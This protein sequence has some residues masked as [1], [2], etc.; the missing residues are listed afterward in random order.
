MNDNRN[1]KE[2]T[3]DQPSLAQRYNESRAKALS[4]NN[5][6]ANIDKKPNNKDDYNRNN[7]IRFSDNSNPNR[8]P[9]SNHPVSPFDGANNQAQFGNNNANQSYSGYSRRNYSGQMNSRTGDN[10]YRGYG[11]TNNIS[12]SVNDKK[13][14][15]KKNSFFSSKSK[16]RSTQNNNNFNTQTSNSQRDSATQNRRRISY[17]TQ[18]AQDKFKPIP[19][20]G[21]KPN[22]NVTNRKHKKLNNIEKL[23]LVTCLIMFTVSLGLIGRYILNGINQENDLNKI[24]AIKEQSFNEI[25]S[26]TPTNTPIPTPIPSGYIEPTPQKDSPI[27]ADMPTSIPNQSNLPSNSK[28]TISRT[29]SKNYNY[30]IRDKFFDLLDVN[31]DIVG[32]IK[33]GDFLDQPVVKRDNSFYI[34]HNF[35]KESNPAG[36]IFLDESVDLKY[37]PENIVVH[38]HNMKNGSMF[39]KLVHY[40]IESGTSFYLKYPTISFDSLYE[41][42]QYVIFAVCEVETDYHHP[43]YFPFIAYTSFQSDADAAEYIQSVKSRSIFNVPIDVGPDDNLITLATCSQTSKSTRLLVVARKIRDGE[44]MQKLKDD[45]YA[46]TRIRK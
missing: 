16:S 8:M 43:N 36:A 37:P 3:Y 25:V 22:S 41:D 38:G 30:R 13:S 34:T 35:L 26:P 45:I 17:N 21:K 19:N 33:I 31:E 23:I 2:K 24:R 44:N 32:W 18:D 5:P 15:S 28:R 39:G 20:I 11:P 4:K 10:S 27:V 29:Y 1:S 14:S 46:T 12:N 9:N 6:F 40:K 7:T 42:A